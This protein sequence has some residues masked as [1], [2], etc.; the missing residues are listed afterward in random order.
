MGP[1]RA[2]SSPSA[3]ITWGQ[4]G[5]G[6]WLNDADERLRDRVDSNI[7]P[8]TSHTPCGPEARPNIAAASLIRI[9]ALQAK[10]LEDLIFEGDF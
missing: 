4:P 1:R 8:S 6:K 7:H 2:P 3:S 10:V 9:K 5:H